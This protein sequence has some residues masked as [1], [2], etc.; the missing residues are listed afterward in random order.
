[1]LSVSVG[2]DVAE[3]IDER[4]RKPPPERG[5]DFAPLQAASL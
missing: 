2:G 5:P 3:G 4:G 1:M